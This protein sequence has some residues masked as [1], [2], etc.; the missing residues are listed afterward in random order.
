MSSNR[1]R[2]FIVRTT[3]VEGKP[4]L[5]FPSYVSYRKT[6]YGRWHAGWREHFMDLE[7]KG[8]LD[9]KIVCTGIGNT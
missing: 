9:G 8:F 1:H 4:D 6:G 3:L 2:C 5:K 7:A